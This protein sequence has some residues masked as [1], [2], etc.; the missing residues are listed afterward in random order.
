[1]PA[2]DRLWGPWVGG[3]QCGVHPSRD[4]YGHIFIMSEGLDSFQTC[5]ERCFGQGEHLHIRQVDFLQSTQLTLP[6][7]TEA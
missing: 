2:G 4:S 3:E 7:C 6:R 1:V 5:N